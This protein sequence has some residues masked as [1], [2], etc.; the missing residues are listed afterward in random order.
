[1]TAELSGAGG[2]D[3]CAI[4]TL[5]SP[6]SVEASANVSTVLFKDGNLL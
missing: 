2:A 3:S 1:V 6:N 4:V 5:A